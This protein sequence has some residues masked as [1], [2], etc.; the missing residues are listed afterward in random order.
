MNADALCALRAPRLGLDNNRKS[1]RYTCPDAELALDI[2]PPA[3]ALDNVFDDSKAKA[4]SARSPTAPRIRS[5]EAAG[6]VWH[7]FG[8]NAVT[9][10]GHCVARFAIA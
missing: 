8:G 4:C 3:V 1:D 10:I 6:E 9:L 5:I 2:E 7:V